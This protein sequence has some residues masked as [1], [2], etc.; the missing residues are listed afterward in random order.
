[1]QESHNRHYVGGD[2]AW[3]APILPMLDTQLIYNAINFSVPMLDLGPFTG[4][5]GGFP[6]NTTAGLTFLPTFICPSESLIHPVG[7]QLVEYAQTNYAGN[8][9]G[10][11]MLT[12]CNGL[13]VPANGDLW[14]RPAG[15]AWPWA[16][17]ATAGTSTTA[18][19]SEPLRGVG[20]GLD[21]PSKP[22][23]AAGPPRAR[24]ALSPPPAVPLTA[25]TGDVATL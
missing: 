11:A 16:A 12:S 25:D 2:A 9:G 5:P 13:I 19:F 21:A 3:A 17:A 7:A 8:Y 14:T 1:G 20:S 15:A 18:M 10:P 22:P 23:P 4:F 6:Q 24:G